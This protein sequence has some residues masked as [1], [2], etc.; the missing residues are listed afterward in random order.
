[1]SIPEEYLKMCVSCPPSEFIL[2]D[3]AVDEKTL[4][5]TSCYRTDDMTKDFDCAIKA[6]EKGK[7]KEVLYIE[8]CD[9]RIRSLGIGITV[10][11]AKDLSSMLNEMAS[12]IESRA[13]DGPIDESSDE[14]W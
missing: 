7:D 12:F 5:L 6:Y 14:S 9:S 10:Q 11:Q 1:M 4:S 8:I 3:V 13:Q 2:T